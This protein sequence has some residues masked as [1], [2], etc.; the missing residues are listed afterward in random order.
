MI[1][2]DVVLAVAQTMRVEMGKLDRIPVRPWHD[3]DARNKLV[4][5]RLAQVA[6]NTINHLSV[7][8]ESEMKQK[9]I[10]NLRED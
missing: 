3:A 4:W 10:T 7:G 6:V 5:L 9:V 1:N 2:D 8:N